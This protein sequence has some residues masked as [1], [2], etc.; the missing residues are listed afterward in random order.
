[1][2]LFFLRR[3]L[4]I[5]AAVVV[6]MLIYSHYHGIESRRAASQDAPSSADHDAPPEAQQLNLLTGD[7]SP[8]TN[9]AKIPQKHPVKTFI[10]LPVL[11]PKDMVPRI[12]ASS[13]KSKNS[14]EAQVQQDRLAAVLGNFT[15]AWRGYRERAWL[16][17]E[18]APISGGANNPFAGWGA[19]LVD[20]LG[21][22]AYNYA[23]ARYS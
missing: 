13:F 5:V 4:P 8:D 9:W 10:T 11:P 19:T 22:T 1:M 7:V 16:Q 15:H 21:K 20:A 23:E 12:Q 6:M 2:V 18:V 3:R 14:T 17:D